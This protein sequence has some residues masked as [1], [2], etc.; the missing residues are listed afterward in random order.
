MWIDANAGSEID[1]AD[2]A[3]EAGL[4]PFHFLRVFTRVVGVTPHQYLVRARLRR[5]ARLLVEAD[6][7]VT[8]VAYESG[9]AD[10]SNFMRSFRRAAGIT[11]RMFRRQARGSDSKILQERFA[12]IA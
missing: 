4:S 3:A 1:L 12:G 11:P 2:A 9:F 6:S 7:P 10:L 8:D 5:A